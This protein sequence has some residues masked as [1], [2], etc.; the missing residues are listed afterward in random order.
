[1]LSDL[2]QLFFP[3]YCANCRKTL[4]KTGSMLCTDCYEKIPFRVQLYDLSLKQNLACFFNVQQAY[5]LLYFKN[6]KISTRLVH[7][8]KYKN[9]P[10]IGYE[11]GYCLGERISEKF[12]VIIPIPLHPKKLKKRGYNQSEEI[13]KGIAEKLNIPIDTQ[14]LIRVKNNPSQAHT[15]NHAERIQN[16]LAIFEVTSSTFQNK[17]ILLVDDIITTGATLY[18]S[19]Y[20]LLQE[21]N[22]Q[23]SVAC[24]GFA[25]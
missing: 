22:V 5:S 9:K 13:A 6:Q 7:H 11:L 15:K 25:G 20:V 4:L 23:I 10:Q 14:S 21:K 1:M 24:I 2:F 16:T 8:L 3:K 18:N 17:H 12:D 19:A